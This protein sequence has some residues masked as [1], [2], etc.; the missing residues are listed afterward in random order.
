MAKIS[1]KLRYFKIKMAKN[2]DIEEHTLYNEIEITA[3]LIKKEMNIS[4]RVQGK[5][6]RKHH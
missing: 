6:V 3:A 1:T 5:N 2:I 4:P